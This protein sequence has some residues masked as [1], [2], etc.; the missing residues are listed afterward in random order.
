MRPTAAQG[1]RD[2]YLTL[3]GDSNPAA[4]TIVELLRKHEQAAKQS[5]LIRRVHSGEV[6]ITE[7]VG[8]DCKEAYMQLRQLND[9]L[10]R[11]FNELVGES[12]DAARLILSD[13]VDRVAAADHQI[14]VIRRWL[15]MA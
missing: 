6:L 1:K 10:H 13:L 9:I 4:A 8:Q 3:E 2:A 12:R 15:D 7:Q 5:G 11:N 14:T